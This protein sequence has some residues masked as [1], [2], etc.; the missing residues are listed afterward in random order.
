LA[1]NYHTN[2]AVSSL[3]VVCPLTATS[4]GEAAVLL[5]GETVIGDKETAS[6]WYFP[7][8]TDLGLL[9]AESEMH[10]PFELV[11]TGRGVIIDPTGGDENGTV[12]YQPGTVVDQDTDPSGHYVIYVLDD[13]SVHW[14]STTGER[15]TLA[16]EGFRSASW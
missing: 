2:T 9:V 8:F 4:V 16:E 3:L 13:G 14:L 12:E 5:E 6:T 1:F 15:G 10:P 7:V 11:S